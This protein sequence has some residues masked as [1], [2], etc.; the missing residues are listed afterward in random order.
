MFVRL[1]CDTA[2]HEQRVLTEER[3]RFGKITSVEALREALAR[4]NF[5]GTVRAGETLEVDNSALEA[6]AVAQRIASHFS[7]PG[8]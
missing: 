5:A 6:D 1:Y 3:R 4:W 2:T 8:R 7:L